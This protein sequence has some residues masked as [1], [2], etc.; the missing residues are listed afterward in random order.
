MLFH[1]P[2]GIIISIS[3]ILRK[4]EFRNIDS[5]AKDTILYNKKQS[6][7]KDIQPNFF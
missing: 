4:I 6:L 1:G 3:T 7:D 5:F 2:I